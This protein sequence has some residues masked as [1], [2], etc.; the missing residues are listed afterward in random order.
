M[1][2]SSALDVLDIE[3]GNVLGRLADIISSPAHDI[4]LVRGEHEYLIPAV[5]EFIREIDPDGGLLR[6]VKILE[7]MASDENWTL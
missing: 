3:S 5:P 4:Y 1:P 7:G 6:R 2:I